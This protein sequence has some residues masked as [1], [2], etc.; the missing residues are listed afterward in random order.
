MS[1]YQNPKILW[2]TEGGLPVGRKYLEAASQTNLK[3]GQFYYL[4]SGAVTVVASDPA[5]IH[6]IVNEDA[7]GTTSAAIECFVIGP[8][9]LIEMT[10]TGGTPVVGNA[11]GVAVGSNKCKL[12][13]AESTAKCFVV[14]RLVDSTNSI[15]WVRP[16]IGKGSSTARD[17]P[18]QA[19]FGA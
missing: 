13:V 6:G 12:D 16:W 5:L 14:D 8:F 11:Y 18:F 19:V 1:L 10:Y 4:N 9:D 2:S 7:S 17:C 15:V 3:Q